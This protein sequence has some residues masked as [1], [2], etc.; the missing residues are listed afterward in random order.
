M[1][2]LKG[3]VSLSTSALGGAR[4]VRLGKNLHSAS[5][6]SRQLRG[7]LSFVG[8]L[9]SVGSSL[10]KWLSM[11][12]VRLWAV[13]NLGRPPAHTTKASSNT[14]Q[15]PRLCQEQLI[16]K[17]TKAKNKKNARSHFAELPVLISMHILP[18]WCYDCLSQ[19]F[20]SFKIIKPG[21]SNESN[22]AGGSFGLS[23]LYCDL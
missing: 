5:D 21:I 1:C 7:I 10:M 4:P 15:S 6:F 18:S 17:R 2:Q 13:T 3:Q 14:S 23:S 19:F 20:K 16:S 8:R 11:F 22:N 12:G 9:A